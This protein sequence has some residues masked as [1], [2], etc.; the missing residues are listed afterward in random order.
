MDLRTTAGV[1]ASLPLRDTGACHAPFFNVK[2]LA[3]PVSYSVTPMTAV[4]ASSSY[5][6]GE[7]PPNW[8]PTTRV[9][10]PD[11]VE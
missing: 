1:A 8:L 2:S 10:Q 7:A 4:P 6:G 3:S 11:P 5:T 9:A